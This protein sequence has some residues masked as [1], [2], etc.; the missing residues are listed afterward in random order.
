[1]DSVYQ[2]M[3]NPTAL[4]SAGA[5]A[6]IIMG[7]AGS[8]LSSKLKLGLAGMDRDKHLATEQTKQKELVLNLTREQ[9]KFELEKLA[10]EEGD[11][12]HQRKLELDEKEYQRGVE[13]RSYDGGQKEEQREYD[14]IEIKDKRTHQLAMAEK[15]VGLK[16][17]LLS[18]LANLVAENRENPSTE[19]IGEREA[20]RKELFE[21]HVTEG[22]VISE[23]EDIENI[24]G[25]IEALVDAKFPF[26]ES[27]S[28]STPM[29]PQL[30]K[31][32]DIVVED[33]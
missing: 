5:I 8:K 20:Y 33:N 17:D 23:D 26:E 1:M 30:K 24:S 27:Q 32:I 3:Q 11:A 21:D 22:D 9:N 15:L 7:Y 4:I 10:I 13:Q 18:Y 29:P 25:Q 2:L 19:L 12:Q 31:L 14:V 28:I 6:G 16:Q